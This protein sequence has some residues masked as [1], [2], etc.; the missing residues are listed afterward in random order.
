MCKKSMVKFLRST[1]IW[2]RSKVYDLI[3]YLQGQRTCF[4]QTSSFMHSVHI[5]VYI[6]YVWSKNSIFS[7]FPLLFLIEK[8][9]LFGKNISYG[10]LYIYSLCIV[11]LNLSMLTWV[12]GGSWSIQLCLNKFYFFA[13][14]KSDLKTLNL[15]WIPNICVKLVIFQYYYRIKG[16]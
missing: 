10:T 9:L 15:D 13:N 1:F 16:I 8:P 2:Q 12:G 14:P 6:D 11:A 5:F 7:L 3:Q 4:A